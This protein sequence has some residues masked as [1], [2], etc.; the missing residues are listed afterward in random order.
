MDIVTIIATAVY[1]IFEGIVVLLGLAL[2]GIAVFWMV[3]LV[4]A[5]F[6]L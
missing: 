4:L 3:L 1:C 5:F 6:G 2:W